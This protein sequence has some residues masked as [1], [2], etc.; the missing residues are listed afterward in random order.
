M[1]K[2]QTP[3][4]RLPPPN[5]I[6][7]LVLVLA[8]LLLTSIIGPVVFS[9]ARRIGS[10]DVSAIWNPFSVQPIAD[11]SGGSEA[12]PTLPGDTSIFG[13][14]PAGFPTPEP[15]NGSDRVTILLMGLDYRDWQGGGPSR[16]DT[17]MLLTIDPITKTAGVLSIPRDLWAVIP[18]F[19]PGKI[20]TAY[21]YGELYKVPG[22]GPAL[23]IETVE[24]TIGVPIDYY[25]QIDFETFVRFIDMIGGVKIDIPEAIKVDPLGPKIPRW[26]DPGVQTLPGDIALAYARARY[27]SGGDF[28][29][30]ARQQQ[31]IFG[32]RDRILHAD[33][34]ATMIEKAPEIY[35]ELSSGID[36]NLPLEDAIKL[37]VLASQVPKENIKT[38][39][40]DQSYITFGRSPDNLSIL[41]PIPDRIRSLRDEIFTSNGPFQ[42]ITAGNSKQR[43]ALEFAAISIQNGTNDPTIAQKTAD[44]L[45]DL[46]ANV[47]TVTSAEKS[48]GQTVVIDHSGNPFTIQFLIEWM[49]LKTTNLYHEFI[50][51]SN[52]DIEIK[53]GSDWLVKN[54]LP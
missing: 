23:A 19:N 32:I 2:K 18:S 27:T 15:W 10:G 37:A 3:L 5:K 51:N 43:L 26:I 44:Y 38:G 31:I 9:Y 8:F 35:A 25:A 30:A 21:Y 53:I 22:G 52:V 13:E 48:Y 29:R 11:A 24:Q 12:V 42:P 39:I 6:S 4:W 34:L 28:D 46:G 14:S 47:I 41:I 40:I 54:A 17:M 36:T 16:T 49:G 33:T 20:N 7:I 1:S 45:T 50:P